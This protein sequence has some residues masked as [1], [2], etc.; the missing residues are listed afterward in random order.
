M[1]VTLGKQ[2]PKYPPGT[3]PRHPLQAILWIY[4]EEHG[5]PL[6]SCL[7]S[8][9]PPLM[10]D[11]LRDGDGGCFMECPPKGQGTGKGK[12]LDVLV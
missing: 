3:L 9:V 8:K 11:D 4:L 5:G 7:T 12:V 1:L 6:H 2:L 10:D